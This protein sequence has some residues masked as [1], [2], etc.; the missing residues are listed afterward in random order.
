MKIQRLLVGCTG[1]CIILLALVVITCSSNSTTHPEL[2]PTAPSQLNGSAITSNSAILY[3]LDNSDDEDGFDIFR[4]PIENQFWIRI[5]RLPANTD[6]YIDTDLSDSTTYTYYVRAFNTS[7]N[8]TASAT[9]TLT[10]P[11][12]GLPPDAPRNQIPWNGVDSV[13][14]N[15]LFSWECIDLDG[16]SLTFDVRLGLD[17]F[18]DI[19]RTSWLAD[20]L[21]PGPLSP[22]TKYYWQVIAKD[23]NKHQTPSPLWYFWTGDH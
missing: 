23:P 3:W 1:L 4:H 6:S 22:N 20:T 18:P 13:L 2:V 10:T 21:S 5:V 7:G 19:I 16:D 17:S 8:S 15:Q 11:A 14:I 12:I 9:Y